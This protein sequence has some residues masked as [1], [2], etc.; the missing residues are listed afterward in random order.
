[1]VAS[2]DSPWQA[3]LGFR[4]GRLF[5]Q[6]WK[7][8]LAAASLGPPYSKSRPSS[9][10][11]AVAQTLPYFSQGNSNTAMLSK[12]L[13]S[14][15]KHTLIKR[16]NTVP[17]ISSW[18][19]HLVPHCSTWEVT[20]HIPRDIHMLFLCS[21]SLETEFKVSKPEAQEPNTP[22]GFITKAWGQRKFLEVCRALWADW[23]LHIVGKLSQRTQI[24]AKTRWILCGG[25]IFTLIFNTGL[26]FNHSL[27]DSS[28]SLCLHP[29]GYSFIQH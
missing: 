20:F 18:Y 4:S 13:V 28:I 23:L 12:G 8:P 9:P 10:L 6:C 5:F 25:W 24:T 19:H 17:T 1:M 29:S 27:Y 16:E 14:F 3:P 7:S 15:A 26:S 21:G 2:M 11:H 22:D